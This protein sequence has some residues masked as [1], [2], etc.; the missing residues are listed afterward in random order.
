MSALAHSRLPEDP[1]AP[2][3]EPA[4][5]LDPARAPIHVVDLELAF[6]PPGASPAS[7]GPNLSE[8]AAGEVLALVRLHGRPVGFV[9]ANIAEAADAQNVLDEAARRELAPA[10]ARHMK[11][12][13][14][15]AESFGYPADGFR[16]WCVRNRL[17]VL[18]QA[19]TVS[20]VIATRERPAELERCLASVC[21][22]SYPDFEVIVVDNA[23]ETDA[24]E[25]LVRERFGFAATYVREPRRGLATAHNRG[26]ALA[27]G[28]IV[29][30]TDDDVIVDE[31]WL[32]AVAEGF[33]AREKV[34]CV[35][36]LIVPAE[37]ETPAQVMLEARGRYAKGFE[38]RHFSSREPD[39]DPLFPF[40]AGHFG[41][42]ANMAFST[43]M[44]RALGGFDPAIGAGSTARGGDDLL[45]FFRTIAAGHGLVYQPGAI[46]WHHH[47][48]TAAAL[49]R[50]AYGYGVGLGAYLAAAVSHEPQTLPSLLRRIPRGIFYEIEQTRP[51]GQTT[52]G[53]T[54]RLSTAQ[55]RGLLYGP[56]AYARSRYSGRKARV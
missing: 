18:A 52:A 28:Q 51:Q 4:I 9:Q 22:L 2:P 50:Q 25:R 34:G 45:A 1:S 32:T 10:I 30:F 33:A 24:T 55:R 14:H 26:L 8:R 54:R 41:S 42:G 6:A 49:E 3:P 37:L 56:I 43:G 38:Q 47:A 35:T 13:L 46:V 44:L 36:G 5:V 31:H 17:R 40:T 12:D 23:P 16:P 21:R 39:A 15:D 29:A 20:V 27:H 48:R 53:W 11:E 19:P 7:A